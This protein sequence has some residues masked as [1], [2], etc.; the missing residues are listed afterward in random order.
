MQK[1]AKWIIIQKKREIENNGKKQA[2]VK[3]KGNRQ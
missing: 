3:K 2:I 1:K